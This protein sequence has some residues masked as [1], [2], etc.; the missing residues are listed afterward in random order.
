MET[1]STIKRTLSRRVLFALAAAL[2]L[3]ICLVPHAASAD[4]GSYPSLRFMRETP[5]EDAKV[6]AKIPAGTKLS[7]TPIEGTSFAKTTYKGIAGY[8]VHLKFRH[9]VWG[10]DSV[11]KET[12]A[13][14]S[15][16]GKYYLLLRKSSNT[17]TVYIGDGSGGHTGEVVTAFTSSVG[18]S[19]TPTV[20]G[21]Y[22]LSGRERWHFFGKSYAPYAVRYSGSK[23]IHGPL[24]KEKSEST[25]IRSSDDIGQNNTGGCLR[26]SLSAAK[27]VYDNCESGT[28]LEVTN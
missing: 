4:T 27:W 10:P 20:S 3:I 14:S 2:L 7:V 6:I 1:T 16:G 26:M 24:Y 15:T 8:V 22:T 13:A 28:I 25:L 9:G 21:K 11:P 17:L 19:S 18:K 5:N 12:A 23:Y